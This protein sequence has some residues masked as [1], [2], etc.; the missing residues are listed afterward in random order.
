MTGCLDETTVLAFLG[1]TLSPAGR[2]TVEAHVAACSA[3][4]EILTWAAADSASASR[5]PGQEGAPFIGQLA[6]GA[7]VDRYQILG[8]VGRGGMGEVYAAYHPDLDRRIA[9][10]IVFESGADAS[11]RRARLLRE[12][13]AIARLSHPNVVTVFDAGTV[14][15]RVYIA[16]EF[17]DGETFD[18]WL[19]SKSRTWKEI[20]DVF[21]A[22]GRGLAAAHAPKVIHRDF[23]PQNVMIARDG[24]VRVMDF[25]LAQLVREDAPSDPGA[26]RGSDVTEGRAGSGG[27]DAGSPEV[28]PTV[29][30]ATKTGEL[31]GTPAYMAP[32]QWRGEPIDERSDQFSFCVAFYEALF[33]ERPRLSHLTDRL[34]NDAPPTPRTRSL[35]PAWLRGV[36]MRGLSEEPNRRFRSMEDLLRGLTRGRTKTRRRVFLVSAALTATLLATGFMKVAHS[37]RISCAPPRDRIAAA[38][39]INDP[40]DQ[41]RESIHRT[42]LATGRATAET[43]WARVSRALDEYVGQWSAM[44]RDACE[45]THVRGEQSGEVL[46]LRM[47]CLTANLDEVHAFAEVL[48]HLDAEALGRAVA[49]VQDL[50]PMRR[51]ADISFL[52]SV[53]PLP[54]DERT[55]KIVVELKRALMEVRALDDLAN[56]VLARNRAEALRPQIEATGY[57]PLLAEVLELI[58]RSESQIDPRRAEKTLEDAFLVAEQSRDDATA[59]LASTTLVYVVGYGLERAEEG[60]RWARIASAILDRLR[61]GHERTQSWVLNNLAAIY[62]SEGDFKQARALLERSVKIKEQALGTDHPDVAISLCNLAD[63]YR[64]LGLMREATE[65]ADRTIAILASHGDPDSATLAEAHDVR[66]KVQCSLGRYDEASH[67]FQEALAIL[68]SWRGVWPTHPES[69]DALNGLAEVKLARREPLAAA[70]LFEQALAVREKGEFDVTLVADTRFGLA[71]A[72]WETGRERWRALSLASD[73]HATFASRHRENREREVAAWLHAHKLGPAR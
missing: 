34:P 16:M 53:V 10:K 47:S 11:E 40:S 35:A 71:Q 42:F 26:A 7:R 27:P 33:G 50:T 41:R 1:G 54:R 5:A 39:P 65:A 19:R 22:A 68:N 17:V 63:C 36:V 2:A 14:G 15:D 30:R 69:G 44:Y 70:R 9:L 60:K 62:V 43:S 73:A 13:R 6:P 52:R 25:G 4:A 32:E 59:A 28:P 23:K 64:N 12:A 8:P 18:E 3:C 57:R 24:S 37:S 55:L 56:F 45:A 31:L 46:D 38:W 20:L 48:A 66:G 51:C 29:T 58:G 61:P 21:V 67:E 49:G 72:L